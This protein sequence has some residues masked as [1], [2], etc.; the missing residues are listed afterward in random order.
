MKLETVSAMGTF[1]T[2]PAPGIP[3]RVYFCSDNDFIYYD[4]GS[5]WAQKKTLGTTTGDYLT[6]AQADARYVQLPPD[7]D[8]KL[9]IVDSGSF[10]LTLLR[11]IHWAGAFENITIT[12]V[13][14]GV[15]K[16]ASGTLT[17]GELYQWIYDTSATSSYR[18]ASGTRVFTT[19]SSLTSGITIDSSNHWVYSGS[20]SASGTFS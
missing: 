15:W 18:A 11:L 6:Q 5:A 4:T 1:A 12:N 3:G 9:T 20:F 13:G 17:S 10:P 19:G 7:Y 14:G 16:A 2:R 8:A